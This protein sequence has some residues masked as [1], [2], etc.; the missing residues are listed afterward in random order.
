[1]NETILSKTNDKLKPDV[2]KIAFAAS[3]GSS[4]VELL[5]LKD[6]DNEV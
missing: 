5:Q 1:V 4:C 2:E 3:C 6:E